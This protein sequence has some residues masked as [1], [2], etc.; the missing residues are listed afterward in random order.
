MDMRNVPLSAFPPVGGHLQPNPPEHLLR[1][2]NKLQLVGFTPRSNAVCF[3][4]SMITAATSFSSALHIRSAV[5][6]A[7]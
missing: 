6:R 7:C 5:L 2:G 1:A 3:A 4:S